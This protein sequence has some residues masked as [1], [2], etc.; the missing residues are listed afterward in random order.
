MTNLFKSLQN[1]IK[2]VDYFSITFQFHY[3]LNNNIENFFRGSVFL[4]F[5]VFSII[6]VLLS[7][8]CFIQIKN[9]NLIN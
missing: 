8:K 4:L 6:Y 5:I 1:L 3:K 2:N 9:I 7:I